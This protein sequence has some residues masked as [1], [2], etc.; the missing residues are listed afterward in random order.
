[1]TITAP[2]RFAIYLEARPKPT[3]DKDPL[4]Y[5][6][7]LTP[8]YK[9]LDGKWCSAKIVRRSVSWYS[10]RSQWRQ[11]SI[12]RGDFS[13][14]DKPPVLPLME[15]LQRTSLLHDRPVTPLEMVSDLTDTQTFQASLDLVTRSLGNI[16]TK[17][18]SKPLFVEV[19]D[20]DV[21]DLS[22]GNTPSALMR[23]IERCR[24]EAGMP[25]DLYE[26]STR[27]TSAVVS[28]IGGMS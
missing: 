12:D 25:E 4:T 10:K 18:V 5:Q 7:V 26:G 9:D 16:E 21:T 23:R 17:T 19:T 13:R 15:S 24:V 11:V 2:K 8:P 3:E 28:V 20:K 1:M 27:F 6:V 14:R 22:R